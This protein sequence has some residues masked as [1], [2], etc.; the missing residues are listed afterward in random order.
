MSVSDR[1][2]VHPAARLGRNVVIAPFALI[3]DNVTIG[4]DCEI[5]PQVVLRAG[6]QIGPGCRLR[7]G[8]V[9]GDP[10]MDSAFKGETTSVR[11][12]RD[13]DLR[14][15][16]TIHRAT[17]EGAAT[18]I[19]DSTLIMPYTH[20]AHNCRIGNSVTITNACQLA[21][22][23]QVEDG[24]VLGGMTGL[25]QFTRVGAHAMAGACSYLSKDLPP[26]MIGAGNP[27]RVR[28]IN[29]VGLQRAGFTP[30]QLDLLRAV[31]RLVYRSNLNLSDALAAVQARFPDSA[32]AQQ[33]MAF[34]RT[35]KRG[36]QLRDEGVESRE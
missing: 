9:I 21:G 6:T 12:G 19:G 8:V 16:V 10:P 13:N 33:F 22:Y 18:T 27:F 26:F 11:L 29:R 1:A 14:E 32:Q 2:V 15:Y 28:G 35:S 25:H 20:V 24:A 3:E 30:E 17:G 4:D 31:H 34:V 5:G 7:T 36:I 23:V